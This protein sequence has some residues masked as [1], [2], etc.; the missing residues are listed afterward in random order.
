MAYCRKVPD[1]VP[2]YPKKLKLVVAIN[3]SPEEILIVSDVVSDISYVAMT[4]ANFM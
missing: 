4:T 2:I 3:L 1:L